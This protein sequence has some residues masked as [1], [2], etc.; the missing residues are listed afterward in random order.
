MTKIKAKITQR[1]KKRKSLTEW[2][3]YCNIPLK[4]EP[5]LMKV[6]R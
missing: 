1:K 4:P 3:S 5:T 6:K 2:M